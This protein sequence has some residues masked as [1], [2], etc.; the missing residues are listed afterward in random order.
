MLGGGNRC[1]RVVTLEDAEWL[2]CR[3]AKVRAEFAEGSRH[4][5]KLRDLK[6]VKLVTNFVLEGADG[7]GEVVLADS[8]HARLSIAMYISP[9]S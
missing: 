1:G 6:V 8:A 9:A 5:R 3:C 4:Y 7:L 2:R